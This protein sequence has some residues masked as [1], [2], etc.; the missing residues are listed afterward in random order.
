MSKVTVH[1]LNQP[2]MY[3]RAK[4]PGFPYI[5]PCLRRLK[6]GSSI[7]CVRYV[8]AQDLVNKATS[9][10]HIKI[11]YSCFLGHAIPRLERES[12]QIWGRQG[13][14]LKGEV[15][16]RQDEGTDLGKG[17]SSNEGVTDTCR[18]LVIQDPHPSQA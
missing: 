8:S 13:L 4:S 15:L 17:W 2:I 7:S 16:L 6:V 3:N 18:D 14:W 1:H 5:N 11:G 9:C 10:C 12:P